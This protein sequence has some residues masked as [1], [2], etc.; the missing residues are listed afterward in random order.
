MPDGTRDLQ[1]KSLKISTI[2][3]L[4]ALCASASSISA[5]HA[6]TANHAPPPPLLVL[7]PSA[8]GDSDDLHALAQVRSALRERSYFDVITYDVDSPAVIRAA[9]EAKHQEWVDHPVSSDDQ[10]LALAHAIGAD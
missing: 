1:A 6:Q 7:Y 8:P 9:N 4:A 10:R 5:T 2:A 3:A